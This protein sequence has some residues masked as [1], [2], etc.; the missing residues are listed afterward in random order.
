MYKYSNDLRLTIDAGIST[1]GPQP[2][3]SNSIK[4]VNCPI[5]FGN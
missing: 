3:R 2:A 4:L 1:K 5:S